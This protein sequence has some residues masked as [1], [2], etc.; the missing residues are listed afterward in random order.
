MWGERRPD[1]AQN[2]GSEIEELRGLALDKLRSTWNEL[3]DQNPPGIRSSDIF[4][5]ML[6]ARIQERAF[7][8]LS[9]DT[10]EWLNKLAKSLMGNRASLPPSLTLKPGSVLTRKWKG[11][12][13]QV[14]VL[15]D[16]FEYEGVYWS[17][18]SLRSTSTLIE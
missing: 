2:T 8:G 4:R 1:M 16:G 5:R 17:T 9:P 6:A 10:K 11:V 15:P 12:T 18:E 14:R 7:G 13:H 3:F